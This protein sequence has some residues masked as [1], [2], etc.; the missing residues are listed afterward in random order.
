MKSTCLALAAM[1]A[2]AAPALAQQPAAP[3]PQTALQRIELAK[4]M[5]P[6]DKYATFIYMVVVAPGGVVGRHTPP[7]IE[8]GY[9]IAGEAT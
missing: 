8:M 5:F 4:Q 3:A 7:G 9:M 1:A 2:L 6:P